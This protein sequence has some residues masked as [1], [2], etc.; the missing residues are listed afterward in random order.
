MNREIDGSS[1][2][3]ERSVK[4]WKIEDGA[5]HTVAA[6]SDAEALGIW[7]EHFI[8]SNGDDSVPEKM[9]E[10]E[11]YADHEELTFALWGDERKIRAR[12]SEW[13]DVFT[14]AAYVG[15]SDF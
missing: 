9:P 8:K 11:P 12:A 15:C 13:L 1:F 14:K 3:K 4:L 7:F 2:G 10:V 6:D 5:T